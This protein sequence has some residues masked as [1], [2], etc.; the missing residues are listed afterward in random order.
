MAKKTKTFKLEKHELKFVNDVISKWLENN[1][2][3]YESD[4]LVNI[5]TMV[6]KGEIKGSQEIAE[7]DEEFK[8]KVYCDYL[9]IENNVYVC[10]QNLKRKAKQPYVLGTDKDIVYQRCIACKRLEG[11]ISW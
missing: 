9:G 1:P 10:Y 4:F 7:L 5:C 2:H 6:D 8:R 3:K 11:R